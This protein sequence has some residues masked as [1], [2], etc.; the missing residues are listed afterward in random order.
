MADLMSG[1][2]EPGSWLRQ[3]DIAARLGVSKI[4]VREA[5]QRLAGIGLLRFEPNRGAV[6]PRLTVADAEENFAL[7]RGIELPLLRR[8]VPRLSI[9]DLAAA[10][11]ALDAPDL[12]VTEANW[13]FHRALYRA[14]GWERGVALAEI[15]HTAIAPYVVL[16]TAE[17]GGAGD[18]D[19]EHRSM[20]RACRRGDGTE[21]VRLLRRH[22]D[23]AERAVVTF[24]SG[25]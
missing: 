17:L 11:L 3:D 10:E 21:S 1:T 8:A 16:Y 15:L 12:A 18:S 14:A 19:A 6:V 25:G 13:A 5:L 4:P 22:L 24:L 2:I 20:L 23:H 7:R 9:V